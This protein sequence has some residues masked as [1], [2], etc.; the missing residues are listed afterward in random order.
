MAVSRS[1]IDVEAIAR[2]WARRGFSCET[3]IDSPGQ[4]WADFV[5]DADELVMPV[6]GEVAFEFSGQVFRP[7]PGEEVLIPAGAVHTVRTGST[8]S[9]WLYGYRRR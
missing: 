7:Q 3:W 9:R 4:V 8:G 2:D 5:H 1:R 6:E